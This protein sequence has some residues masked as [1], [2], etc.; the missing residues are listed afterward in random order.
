MQILRFLKKQ[1]KVQRMKFLLLLKQM[2]KKRQSR[3]QSNLRFHQQMKKKQKLKPN[4][5]NN[6]ML[7]FQL[8]Y[9]DY[10]PSTKA[11][12]SFLYSM[13]DLASTN[14]LNPLKVENIYMQNHTLIQKINIKSFLTTMTSVIT[15]RWQLSLIL[16]MSYRKEI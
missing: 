15:T 1:E 10:K 6:S 12:T 5:I 16:H 4:A 11:F 2:L 7:T 9:S 3:W 14:C 13:S 8:D